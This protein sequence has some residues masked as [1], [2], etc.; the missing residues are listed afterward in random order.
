MG[1]SRHL[2]SCLSR[3]SMFIYSFHCSGWVWAYFCAGAIYATLFFFFLVRKI[4][5]ELTSVPI[6]LYLVCEMPPQ[7][8]LMSSM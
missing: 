3:T 8:D 7:H 5:P 6:F 4:V 2:N 1:Q